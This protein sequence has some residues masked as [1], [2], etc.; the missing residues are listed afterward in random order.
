MDIINF[1]KT[2]FL[3]MCKEVDVGLGAGDVLASHY[4][5]LLQNTD[6][7]AKENDMKGKYNMASDTLVY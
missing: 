1:C 7:K 2:T 3:F 6:W 5:F 4:K